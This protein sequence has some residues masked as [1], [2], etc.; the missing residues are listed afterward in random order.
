MI[1]T[2]PS[3]AGEKQLPP[4]FERLAHFPVSPPWTRP[5]SLKRPDTLRVD[6]S[7]VKVHEI[8]AVTIK[9]ENYPVM[10]HRFEARENPDL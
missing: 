4:G 1:W 10:R 5:P 2:K 9:T 8:K 6:L 3:E 7:S